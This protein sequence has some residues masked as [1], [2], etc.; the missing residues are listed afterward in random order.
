MLRT[1]TYA[2]YPSLQVL[3]QPRIDYNALKDMLKPKP[4]LK[5]SNLL[6]SSLQSERPTAH[7]ISTQG[8][9]TDE[10]LKEMNNSI[11]LKKELIS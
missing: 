7:K 9:F 10:V 1:E 11:Q 5:S 8:S 3:S 2:G 4:N 6:Y